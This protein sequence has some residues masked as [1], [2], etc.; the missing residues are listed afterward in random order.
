MRIV[1]PLLVV[2][3]LALPAAA[4]AETKLESDDDKAIYLMGAMMGRGVPQAGF[5][6]RE[7]EL[8]SRG[9]ADQVSGRDL[10]IDFADFDSETIK[11]LV[12]KRQEKLAEVERAKSTEFLQQ[13]AKA[14]GATT[15]ESGLIYTETVA[16]SGAQPGTTDTVSVHYHGTLRDGSV[17]DSSR[18]R[19]QPA[20]FPINRVIPCWTEALQKMKVGGRAV[21]VC[22]A[23]IAYGD[24]GYGTIKPGAALR[25]EVELLSIQ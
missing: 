22:P 5:S 2:F 3:S 25:F 6:E 21:V 10:L 7:V 4:N 14:K 9:M 11:E 20:E 18:D 12:E 16:G 23:S 15:L 17:F 13:E 8:L 19:G 24:R 1:T